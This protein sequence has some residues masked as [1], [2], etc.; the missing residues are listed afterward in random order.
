MQLS[1]I[2]FIPLELFFLRIHDKIQFLNMKVTNRNTVN[3]NN[4]KRIAINNNNNQLLEYDDSHNHLENKF[5]AAKSIFNVYIKFIY[6]DI[7]QGIEEEEK[8]LP[9]DITTFDEILNESKYYKTK[10][11]ENFMIFKNNDLIF[12]QSPFQQTSYEILFEEIKKNS[13]ISNAAEK[14]SIN[15]NIKYCI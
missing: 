5:E 15:S 6:D 2:F 3:N 11:D 7:S 14:V 9:P 10:R 12:F 4:Y 8:Q 13:S 1:E